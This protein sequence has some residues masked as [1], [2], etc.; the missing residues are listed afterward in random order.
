[1]RI[2]VADDGGGLPAPDRIPEGIGLRTTR[3]RL[4]QLYGDEHQF[5]LTSPPAGGTLCTMVLPLRL[6]GHGPA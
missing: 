1:V 6:D 5:A 4:R 3:A 2:T